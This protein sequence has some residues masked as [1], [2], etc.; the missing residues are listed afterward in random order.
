MAA[1]WAQLTFSL[2]ILQSSERSDM[3]SHWSEPLTGF[4]DWLQMFTLRPWGDWGGSQASA[5]E[6]QMLVN[7]EHREWRVGPAPQSLHI[8]SI[9]ATQIYDPY[10]Y[11]LEIVCP[12]PAVTVT[13]SHLG[14][15]QIMVVSG[16]MG[17]VVTKGGSQTSSWMRFCSISVTQ[18]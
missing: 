2:Q 14:W 12:G 5:A 15:H 4:S 8:D 11:R 16:L 9:S 1:S 10:F 17:Q 18:N 3:I 7:T 6:S 13:A